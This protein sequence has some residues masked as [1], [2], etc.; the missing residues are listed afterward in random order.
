ML[1]KYYLGG[2]KHSH[3]HSH[4]TKV[5]V[6][7]NR[8]PTDESIK[9]LREMEEKIKQDIIKSVYVKNNVVE[10]V[11][12]AYKP[13][14]DLT[15]VRLTIRFKL[16]EI[17]YN[18]DTEMERKPLHLDSYGHDLAKEMVVELYNQVAKKIAFELVKFG[19]KD[20]PEMV[21]YLEILKRYSK[22]IG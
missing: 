14:I 8:A 18:V 1:D 2:S 19:H 17:E 16:N 4:K 9:L 21:E 5:E 12:F 6:T 3:H 10:G 11:V 20:D 15:T 13:P 22:T 7:E